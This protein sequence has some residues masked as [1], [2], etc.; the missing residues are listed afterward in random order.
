M[1]MSELS[2]S[3][4][5]VSL[6]SENVPDKHHFSWSAEHTHQKKKT[7]K[8]STFMVVVSQEVVIISFHSWNS[9]I[10]T[11]FCVTHTFG[12]ILLLHLYMHDVKTCMHQ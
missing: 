4:H 5:C 12:K 10:Y 3:M 6:S 8:Q 7:K 1:H 2:E 9:T 11:K